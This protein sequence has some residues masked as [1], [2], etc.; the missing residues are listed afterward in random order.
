M[1]FMFFA[2][3]LLAIFNV[4]K[5][6]FNEQLH[7]YIFFFKSHNEYKISIGQKQASH[8]Y[9]LYSYVSNLIVHL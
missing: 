6:C 7:W 8:L 5:I 3:S 2:R 1:N 4:Y 9:F